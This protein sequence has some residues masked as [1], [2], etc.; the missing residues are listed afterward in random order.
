MIQVSTFFSAHFFEMQIRIFTGLH[1]KSLRHKLRA[2][3]VTVSHFIGS[4][5]FRF[6]LA[7]G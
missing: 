5:L 7:E 1:A 2:R 6:L 4:D 3:H